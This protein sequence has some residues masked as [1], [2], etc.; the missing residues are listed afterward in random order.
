MLSEQAIGVGKVILITLE[1]G[2]TTVCNCTSQPLPSVIL[3]LYPPYSKLPNGRAALS[4]IDVCVV[5]L[6]VLVLSTFTEYG[7][8]PPPR[9]Y[10]VNSALS[11]GWQP[12][13][14]VIDTVA[15]TCSTLSI[16]KALVATQPRASVR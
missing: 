13:C 6:L 1:L 8:L 12:I 15:L 11:C 16:V 4:E 9:R 10:T 7:V 2:F 3:I 5:S 14:L